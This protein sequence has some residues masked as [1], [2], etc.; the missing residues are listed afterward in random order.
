VAEKNTSTN[1]LLKAI[2]LT[3][4]LIGAVCSLILMFHAGR[5]NKSVILMTVFAIWV[6]SPFVGFLIAN[7]ISKP[8]PIL[9]RLTFYW[10]TIILTIASLV[11]Y[12][13][14]LNPPGTKAGFIFL[15]IPATSWALMLIV[16]L[17]IL[18]TSRKN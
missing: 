8:W 18:K 17:I 13:G 4:I 14:V 6:L 11:V 1:N 10:L 16:I 2:A 7:R 3:I 9:S 15:V 12:S 5:N